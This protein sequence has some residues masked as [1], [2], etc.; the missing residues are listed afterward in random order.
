MYKGGFEQGMVDV[1]SLAQ[2]D[3]MRT[4]ERDKDNPLSIEASGSNHDDRVIAGALSYYAWWEWRRGE[5]Q[6]QGMTYARAQQIDAQGGEDPMDGLL[7]RFLKDK[8]II[9]RADQI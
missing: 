7:R 5:L 8:K 2:L 4:M 1:K 9:V 3:E 6:A